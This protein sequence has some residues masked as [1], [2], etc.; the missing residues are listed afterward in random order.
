MTGATRAVS[1]VASEMALLPMLTLAWLHV[2]ERH[3]DPSLWWIAGAFGISFLADTAALWVDPKTVSAVYP[4]S[5]AALVGA[6]FLSRTDA[7]RLL[8]ALIVTGMASLLWHGA[9]HLDV[10]LHTVAW[11]TVT[12]LALTRATGLLRASLV[13][14]FGLGLVA[15]WSYVVAPGWTSWGALQSARALG[16]ILFCIAAIHARAGL[17]VES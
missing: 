6:V 8:A 5:Q 9:D 4:I 13:S 2:T 1:E 17:H 14:A 15:W 11:G 3:R 7:D 12:G 10:L 16:L